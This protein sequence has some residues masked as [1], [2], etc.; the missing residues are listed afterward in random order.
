M[1]AFADLIMQLTD[2]PLTIY[3]NNQNLFKNYNVWNI[4]F[5]LLIS[6]SVMSF[7]VDGVWYYCYREKFERS[8]FASNLGNSDEFNRGLRGSS[9]IQGESSMP[10]SMQQY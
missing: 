5:F 10:K 9:N 7:W 1:V 2:N 3:R 6:S 4:G 8:N